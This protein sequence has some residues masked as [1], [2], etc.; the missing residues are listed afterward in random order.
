LENE[1][2]PSWRYILFIWNSCVGF[3]ADVWIILN[4][5]FPEE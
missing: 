5:Q 2:P 3:P 4:L 1:G